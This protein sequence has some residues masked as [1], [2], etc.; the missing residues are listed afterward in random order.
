MAFDGATI[1]HV[2]AELRAAVGAHV[3]KIYMPAR[4]DVIL[5]LKWKGG[6]GRLLMTANAGSP[7]LHF[8]S[9]AAENPQTPP[10]F[11]MLLR[12]HLGAARLTD[13]RQDGLERIVYLDFDAVSEIGD[14]VRFTLAVEVM[15][16]RSNIILVNGE[17]RIV[18]A[19]KRVDAEMSS[20]RQ[21]LPGM[22][23]TL[24]PSQQ[25]A[26]VLGCTPEE[27]LE[28]VLREGDTLS[29]QKAILASLQGFSPLLAR[30]GAFAAGADGLD[31][32]FDMD[33]AARGRLLD[34]LGGVAG[35]IRDCGGRPVMLLDED[36][37]PA[38]FTFLPIRQYGALRTL[39]EYP[40][41]SAL[42]DAFYGERTRLDRMKQ[43]SHD[44]LVLLQN[45]RD[46]AARKVAV[47]KQELETSRRREELRLRAELL[48]ANAHGIPRG[49]TSVKLVNYYDPELSEIEIP[50]DGRLSAI[51]NAQKLYAE[52]RK[53]ATAEQMLTGLIEKGEEQVLYLESVLDAV[54][55]SQ[56]ESEL[57]E[58]RR[59]LA[60]T[61]Y[62]KR[63]SLGRSKPVRVPPMRYLS[64]DGFVILAGR[65]N[66]QN[67]R[68]TLR[69]ADRGDIWFHAQ[70]IPGSHVIV[71]TEG[72]EV[73]DRTLTQAAELAA[74][75]SQARESLNVP[76]DYT[77]I[78]CVK[79][80]QGAAPGRVIYT[81]YK[82]AYV[83]P[84]ECG[85]GDAPA[86]R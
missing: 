41:F 45:A 72:R 67:D 48:T 66:L 13:V 33:E 50:L 21:V 47:Q 63:R 30:E 31:H 9:A 73:P 55:R 54:T 7:R 49:S 80:P 65:N 8:T 86:G 81:D 60:E 85:C 11:C 14:P 61:G 68:L 2:C 62:V 57:A 84:K 46:R 71:C 22:A 64:D 39:R 17:G 76:V 24:P 74:W 69:E 53:A 38:D 78:R 44:L 42:L 27:A 37:K 29:L 26:C 28:A 77:R 18:D 32:A 25:T 19:V 43:R 56:G 36:G 52:Y 12:K 15:G 51:E 20:V 10:M 70:K 6:S 34:W 5:A 16:R 35:L 82:T 4:E 83:N 23:Y 79:K 40:S 1:R 3:E 59:E 75:H 58:I